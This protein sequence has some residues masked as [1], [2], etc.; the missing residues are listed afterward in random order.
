MDNMAKDVREG[1]VAHQCA[2][3]KNQSHSAQLQSGWYLR[4]G[5]VK[6][7]RREFKVKSKL[8]F[9]FEYNSVSES[10]G[11]KRKCSGSLLLSQIVTK[12][13]VLQR[14][15]T[16]LSESKR[17]FWLPFAI[18]H[19]IRQRIISFCALCLNS[20]LSLNLNISRQA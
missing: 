9:K 14:A 3:C 5:L 12:N 10:T 20:S 16:F 1:V 17:I 18:F 13:L 7:S 15:R 8:R 19:G 11:I 4:P 2:H 6:L